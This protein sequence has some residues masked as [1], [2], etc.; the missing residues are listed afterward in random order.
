MR[1]ILQLLQINLF[2]KRDLYTLLR[3]DPHDKKMACSD[4]LAF[5]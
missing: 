1:Q 4:Q 3:G 5:L 2:E